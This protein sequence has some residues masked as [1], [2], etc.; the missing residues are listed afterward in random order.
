MRQLRSV[1]FGGGQYPRL[2][3]VL[4][5][6][7]R[8]HCPGWRVVV[9]RVQESTLRRRDGNAGF[10]DNA[11]KL[12]QW[13]RIVDSAPEGD[14]IL[15]V[16]ADV[17]ILAP[18]DELWNKPFD[19]LYT[20]RSEA[21]PFPLNAGVVAVRVNEATRSFMRLW[22]H[23]DHELFSDPDAHR[24][25]RKK[26]GGMNQAS[27]GALLECGSALSSWLRVETAPC[28]EWNACDPEDWSRVDER[29]KIVHVKSD[30][31]ATLF[32]VVVS[33][34]LLSLSRLWTSAERSA[35]LEV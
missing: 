31:R 25:W 7:A 32:S 21:A 35:I 9:E 5:R 12:R 15:L 26:Y 6:T 18:L 33:R 8:Q 11:W 22:V 24:Q 23:K 1:Y 27:L 20:V 34:N 16:D 13:C 17:F 3:A 4:D 19:F 2:A 30:L 10:S 29:T 14:E 28:R